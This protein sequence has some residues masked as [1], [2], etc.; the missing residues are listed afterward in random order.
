MGVTELEK[1]RLACHLC[2]YCITLFWCFL[3]PSGTHLGGSGQLLTL[4][5][6]YFQSRRLVW[7]NK[8]KKIWSGKHRAKPLK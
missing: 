4:F 2:H 8:T 3:A 1:S 5:F 6:L 7:N